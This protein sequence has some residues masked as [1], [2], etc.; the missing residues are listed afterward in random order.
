MEKHPPE[1]IRRNP[2]LAREYFYKARLLVGYKYRYY[3]SVNDQ[4]QFSY[5]QNK[6]TG[7]NR[8]GR[9]CNLIAV[10]GEL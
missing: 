8:F 6:P 3:F 2:A 5:D 9:M 10:A 1:E 4:E 7:K